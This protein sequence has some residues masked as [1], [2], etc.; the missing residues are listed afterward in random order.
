VI[1]DLEQEIFS[2]LGI[3]FYSTI[4]VELFYKTKPETLFTIVAH[5]RV[6]WIWEQLSVP[7]ALFFSIDSS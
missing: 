5:A 3:L 4:I 6:K 7:I 1:R 2:I